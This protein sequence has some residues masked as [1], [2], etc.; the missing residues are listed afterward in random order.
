[1]KK[2]S[3]K[4]EKQIPIYHWK[5]GEVV[6]YLEEKDMSAE[7]AWELEHNNVV[8]IELSPFKDLTY[9]TLEGFGKH[10]LYPGSKGKNGDLGRFEI[11]PKLLEEIDYSWLKYAAVIA[12][13]L[14]TEWIEEYK[15]LNCVVGNTLWE[16]TEKEHADR[17]V[18][19][20]WGD[21]EMTYSFRRIWP[22]ER[23]KRG[24]PEGILI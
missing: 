6:R 2:I 7:L 5:T 16:V 19:I 8:K 17:T 3:Y 9:E 20:F 24:I 13:N 11:E 22:E 12:I 14:G 10:V 21:D 1:M 23:K 4:I 18:T 15:V